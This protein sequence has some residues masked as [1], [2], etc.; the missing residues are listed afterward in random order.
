MVDGN[1]NQE[2]YKDYTNV[3]Q[4]LKRVAKKSH[5]YS[6]CEEFKNNSKKMW[7]LINKKME[8]KLIRHVEYNKQ[9][10]LKEN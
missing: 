6:K 2:E 1:V 3:L 7:N 8:R 9:N 5:Y 10:K 4:K